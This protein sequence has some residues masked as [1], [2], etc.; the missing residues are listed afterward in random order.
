MRN[1]TKIFFMAGIFVFTLGL[2]IEANA[3]RCVSEFRLHTHSQC[4][5]RSS[6][7]VSYTCSNGSQGAWQNAA[8]SDGPIC[9]R[10]FKIR[11]EVRK[12]CGCT[13]RSERGQ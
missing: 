3:G 8:S 12:A 6:T 7:G 4:P 13:L 2:S 5:K 1:C 9:T 11:R 10:N